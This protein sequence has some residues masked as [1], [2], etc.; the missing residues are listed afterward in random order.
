MLEQVWVVAFGDVGMA[1][2]AA[3]QVDFTRGLAIELAKVDGICCCGVTSQFLEFQDVC[4][5][6]E[7]FVG[8]ACVQADVLEKGHRVAGR[9]ADEG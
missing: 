6:V 5:E 1:P 2:D 8:E 9:R 7:Y 3:Y 4:R